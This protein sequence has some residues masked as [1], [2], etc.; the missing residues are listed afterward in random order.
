TSS[1]L[2]GCAPA[3]SLGINS[4]PTG[5]AEV[6]ALSPLGCWSC[7]TTG[8]KIVQL[9]TGG[10]PV[11]PPASLPTGAV[12]NS[13]TVNPATGEGVCVANDNHVYT[14]NT[15]ARTMTGTFLSGA[16]AFAGFSGGSCKNCGVAMD[17]LN[18]HAVI[19]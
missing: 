5:P 16:D 18:N 17:A 8:V 15:P 9:E 14:F 6:S 7:G 1:T 10:G 3:S 13:C 4:P 11:I 12:V 2:S 19:G